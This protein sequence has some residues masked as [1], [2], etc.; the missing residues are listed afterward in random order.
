M[1][2][3]LIVQIHFAWTM[4]VCAFLILGL[5]IIANLTVKSRLSPK[6]RKLDVMEFVRPL[7]EP[8]FALVCI[9]SFFFFFGT[10]LPF[11]YVIL[12]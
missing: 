3:K 11:N 1:V 6:P 12:Q 9:A 10:F 2:T 4:R 5:L 8:A 7:K